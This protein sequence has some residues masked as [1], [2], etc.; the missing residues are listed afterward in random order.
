MFD[1]I[2]RNES[3]E[4][5]KI[6]YS[7]GNLFATMRLSLGDF[8]FSLISDEA[9][10]KTHALFWVMWIFIVLFSSLIFLNFVI[11]EVGESYARIKSSVDL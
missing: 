8:D 4:Y 6:G 1:V 3:T 11:A 7:F 5:K 9:L 10:T 2:A